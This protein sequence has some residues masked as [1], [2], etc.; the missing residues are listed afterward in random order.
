MAAL[1]LKPTGK[2]GERRGAARRALAAKEQAVALL[3]TLTD[4]WS[5]L[6]TAAKTEALRQGV[7]LCLRVALYVITQEPRR[8]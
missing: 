6:T 8:R 2:A 4:G 7:V 5:E 3:V 1:R